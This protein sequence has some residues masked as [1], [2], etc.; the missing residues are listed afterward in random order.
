MPI[1]LYH[2]TIKVLSQKQQRLFFVNTFLGLFIALLDISTISVLLYSLHHVYQLQTNITAA[3]ALQWLLNLTN[4]NI[5]LYSIAVL[6]VVFAV[7]LIKN[8]VALFIYKKHLQFI[9]SVATG[10]AQQQL[11]GYFLQPFSN[12]VETTTGEQIRNTGNLTIEFAQHLVLG[13]MNIISDCIFL[14][15]AIVG[16]FIYSPTLFALLII[17]LLPCFLVIQFFSKKKLQH[18]RQNIKKEHGIGLQYLIEA[19]SNYVEAKI[20]NTENFFVTRYTQ[21][22]KSIN[23]NLSQLLFMQAIPNRIF[24]LCIVI[25]SMVFFMYQQSLHQLN[26]SSLLVIGIFIAASLKVVGAFTKIIANISQAKTYS[27]TLTELEKIQISVSETGASKT[28]AMKSNVQIKNLTYCFSNRIP[29]LNNVQL[30]F[31]VGAITGIYGASGSGKSTLLHL[32]TGLIPSQVNILVDNK[33]VD[34][35]TQLNSWQQQIAFVKQ[36]FFLIQASIATNIT[37]SE[38]AF[39]ENKLNDAIEQS[40]L[41]NFIQQQNNGVQTIVQD[42]GKNISGGEK[43]RIAI[44]RALYHNRNILILDESL[45]ELDAQNIQRIIQQLK[46]IAAKGKYI[47]IVSH[48]PH[49]LKECDCLYY[50]NN[51]EVNETTLYQLAN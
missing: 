40:G 24:E 25:S 2:R 31:K 28:I 34:F 12:H 20:Y 4:Y 45:N 27:F 48:Q 19:I 38:N 47:I 23:N 30:Q 49:V 1:D 39:D 35:D 8:A 14:F 15:I 22:Q 51:G 18:I 32:L 44:A 36:S 43:Q 17:T 41:T 3:N 7:L 6:S 21:Q 29:V 13:F 10:F 26:S 16:I 9:S 42:N 5:Q 33:P 50:L 46:Q 11:N 37:L